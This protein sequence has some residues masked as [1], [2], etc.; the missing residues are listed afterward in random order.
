MIELEIWVSAFFQKC[1]AYTCPFY[2]VILPH[3]LANILLSCFQRPVTLR[4]NVW[5]IFAGTLP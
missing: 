2:R 3:I 5:N 1:D 4:N